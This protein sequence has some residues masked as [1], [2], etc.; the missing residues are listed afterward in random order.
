MG[1]PLLAGMGRWPD[2]LFPVTTP[3]S[4]CASSCPVHS[5]L[6][7]CWELS[8]IGFSVSGNSRELNFY[9]GSFEQSQTGSLVIGNF[10]GRL[11]VRIFFFIF[12]QE[13]ECEIIVW[14]RAFQH[15]Q[16]LRIQACPPE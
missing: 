13:S 16:H 6:R 3:G 1:K 9:E 14:I 11:L 2:Q 10:P 8:G 15:F 5:V 4:I 7:N 12:F